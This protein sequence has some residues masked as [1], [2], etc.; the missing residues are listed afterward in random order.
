MSKVLAYHSP[1][2]SPKPGSLTEPGQNWEGSMITG[3]VLFVEQWGYTSIA[4]MPGMFYNF[5]DW[6]SFPQRSQQVVLSTEPPQQPHEK[7]FFVM[8]SKCYI[9]FSASYF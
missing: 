6:N 9:I 5:W 8:T 1:T 2:L 4:V 7:Y 3:I